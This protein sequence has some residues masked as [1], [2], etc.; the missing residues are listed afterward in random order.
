MIQGEFLLYLI[1]FPLLFGV[2]LALTALNLKNLFSRKKWIPR[3][4][5]TLTVCIGW[6]YY[7]FLIGLSFKPSGEYYEVVDLCQY[8]YTISFEYILS[9]LLPCAVGVVGFFI[10]SYSKPEN[11]PPLVSAVSIA[12]VLIGNIM[13]VL[14]FLQIAPETYSKDLFSAFWLYLYHFNL[15]IISIRQIHRHICGQVKHI[16][17]RETQFRHKGMERLYSLM[18]KISGMSMLSF[19]LIF[20]LAAILEIILLLFG[21]G[22]DGFIKAFTMTADWNFSTQIPPPPEMYDGHYLCTV[23]AGGHRKLVRPLRYGTRL[24]HTIIVNRQLAVSNAFEELLAQKR[25]R[26]H[27]WV[28]TFYNRHGYPLSKVITTPLRADIVYILMKPLEWLFLLTL[29]AWDVHPENRIAVQ[30]AYRTEENV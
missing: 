30:Y 25:P 21:Q 6:I 12:A 28:R 7:I 24:S 13:N 27:K 15:L 11:L 16:Q 23:A 26:F 29:Y 17:E 10:L 8:H 2:P 22:P 4:S 18:S 3:M 1:F 19:L 14:Y 20:P 5:D 9:F